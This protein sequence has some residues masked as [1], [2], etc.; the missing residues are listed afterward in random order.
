MTDSEMVEASPHDRWLSFGKKKRGGPAER[1]GAKEAGF[2]LIHV[3][4]SGEFL[5]FSS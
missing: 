4:G 2:S 5:P 3:F 1:K